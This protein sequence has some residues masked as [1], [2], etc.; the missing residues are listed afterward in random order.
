MIARPRLALRVGIT[1][2]RNIP[3]EHEARVCEQIAD[4]LCLVRQEVVWSACTRDARQAYRTEPGG[5]IAP[6]LR[7]LSPL[8]E[9]AD[10]LAARIAHRQSWALVVPMPFHREDYEWD[11]KTKE[12]LD[13]FRM[14]LGW[15]GE[16][17]VE[18]DGEGGRH[19]PARDR[20]D[21]WRCYEAVGRFVARNCDLLIAV[22]NGRPGQGR[23]GTADIVQFAAESGPPVWWIQADRDLPP[24]WIDDSRDLRQAPTSGPPAAQSLRDFLK[25]LILPP[26]LA[27]E[28]AGGRSVFEHVALLGQTE[29]SPL[30]SYY[31]EA[32]LPPRGWAHLHRLM[33]D[34]ATCC[35]STRPREQP[36]PA[37]PV[38][39][40]W[41]DAYRAT[42]ERANEYAARD[43]SS[44]VAIFVLAALALVFAATSLAASGLAEPP[45]WISEP[46]EHAVKL[47]A[48]VAELAA[49]ALILWFVI[50]NIRLGWHQRW[51]DYRLLAELYRKQQALAVL[52]WSLS[53]RA[54][55]VLAGQSDRRGRT[56]S[57]ATWLVWLFAAM[58]REAPM[59]QGAFDP[60]LCRRLRDS[61]RADL[62]MHQ[63][64]YHHIRL[65]ESRRAGQFFAA[66]GALLFLLVVLIV[67]AKFWLVRAF[68]PVPLT[69]ALGLAAAIVPTIAAASVGIRAYAELELLVE[70]SRDMREAMKLARRHIQAIDPARPLASQELGAEVL[71][72]ATQMLQDVDGWA[73]LFRGKLVEAG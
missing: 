7:F 33:L 61:A 14:M 34:V 19:D 59:P 6:R 2:A 1:G 72:V 28:H 24:R 10:R 71:T 17:T 4:V 64:R 66:A 51:I 21:E 9:G 56:R 23:G 60:A 29:L 53:G 20:D 50:A 26:K 25:D 37:C 47:A 22:W 68:A 65:H 5:R 3:P 38:A 35:Y 16:D 43:R 69:T 54:V 15:A 73:R 41:H 39:T 40:W 44:Y 8:A 49:L 31:A 12:S 55:Q 36:K 48:T 70:Q 63:F 67:A 52:G 58:V 45:G 13:E 11:F 32:P 27:P 62:V 18:L 42:N 46:C 57:R 30:E